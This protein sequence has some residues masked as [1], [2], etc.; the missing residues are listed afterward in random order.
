MVAMGKN[1]INAITKK[2][3]IKKALNC[4]KISPAGIFGKAVWITNTFKPTG[5]VINPIS[6]NFTINTP[7]QIKFQ[8]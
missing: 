7:N 8:A 3:E 5:G 4:L 6:N 1:T 2:S